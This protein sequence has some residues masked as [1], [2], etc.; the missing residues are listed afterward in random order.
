[1][2]QQLQANIITAEKNRIIDREISKGCDA[3][4]KFIDGGYDVNYGEVVRGR[5]QYQFAPNINRIRGSAM[6]DWVTWVLENSTILS[7]VKNR[8][9]IE[10]RIGAHPN[11]FT[12]TNGRMVVSI[13]DRS[14]SNWKAR[15]DFK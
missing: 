8:F 11:G 13:I 4:L 15:V 14:K 12:T 1:M 7:Q 3:F 10:N 2:E 6:C 5:K 9:N